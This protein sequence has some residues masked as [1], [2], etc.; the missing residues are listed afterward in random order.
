[1]KGEMDSM[2]SS[3]K[4]PIREC[5]DEF[6]DA[7]NDRLNDLFMEPV[8]DLREFVVTRIDYCFNVE[9][10]Y[11]QDYLAFLGRAFQKTDTYPD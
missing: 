8:I 10:P 5:Y 4:Q 7:V 9:T 1:M 3:M 11:V 2:M 6:L